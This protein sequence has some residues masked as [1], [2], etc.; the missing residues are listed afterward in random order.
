MTRTRSVLFLILKSPI[1]Y[2]SLLCVAIQALST[3]GQSLFGRL[4]LDQPLNIWLSLDL[5]DPFSKLYIPLIFSTF[6]HISAAHLFANLFFFV[7]SAYVFESRNRVN[8]LFQILA[9]SLVINLLIVG[10]TWSLNINHGNTLGISALALSL[11]TCSI[12]RR[13]QLNYWLIL[14]IMLSLWVGTENYGRVTLVGHSLGILV[15]VSAYLALR[16]NSKLA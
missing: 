11:A 15:G 2:V 10:V 7:V 6:S 9:M 4:S 16:S 5:G 14:P 13:P 12:L 8:F 3:D 1:L